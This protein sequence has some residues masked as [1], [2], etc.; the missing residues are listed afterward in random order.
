MNRLAQ[1]RRHQLRRNIALGGEVDARFNQ[2]HRLED[3]L[4]PVLRAM[5]EQSLQLMQR[6]PPLPVGVGMNEI[7]E[8]F[9]LGQ[10][11]LAVLE[12]A[13]RELAGLGWTQ[14]FDFS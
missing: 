1:R 5:A 7:I 9:G 13:A 12:R 3:L 2:R 8:T 6:L 10:I 4:A 14:A 11:K